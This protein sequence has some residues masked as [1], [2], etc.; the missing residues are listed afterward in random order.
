MTD[1]QEMQALHVFSRPDDV[2]GCG[3]VFKLAAA[4]GAPP[5][6]FETE[7]RPSRNIQE[8]PTG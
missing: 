4:A 6:T 8:M 2:V 3:T 1:Q 5:E 7:G